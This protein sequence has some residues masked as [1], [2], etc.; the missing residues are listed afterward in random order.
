[1]KRFDPFP[2]V[3]T[4]LALAAVPACGGVVVESASSAA[5][6]V[7]CGTQTLTSVFP[8]DCSAAVG[9]DAAI[10]LVGAPPVCM[11]GDGAGCACT[12]EGTN[13]WAAVGAVGL[14]GLNA[15]QTRAGWQSELCDVQVSLEKGEHDVACGQLKALE[16]DI[17]SL[18][19][20]RDADI[21]HDD[22][23][24]LRVAVQEVEAAISAAG[25]RCRSVTRSRR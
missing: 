1:M 8:T 24:A 17:A 9:Y 23:E 6:G 11:A 16:S 18:G 25:T 22:A 2:A 3:L 19:A 13:L 15:E 14:C 4:V 10:C 5:K 12:G 21:Q 7:V 20:D